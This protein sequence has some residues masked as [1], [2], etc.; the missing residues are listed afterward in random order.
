MR[1]PRYGCKDMA[2]SLVKWPFL[3]NAERKIHSEGDRWDASYPIWVP[4]CLMIPFGWL[5]RGR[6]WPNLKKSGERRKWEKEQ[7]LRS[8]PARNQTKYPETR[9]SPCSLR[10]RNNNSDN[11]STLSLDQDAGLK[12]SILRRL[13]LE[14]RQE[15]YGY[16]LGREEN[17]LILLPF[18]IRAVP[19]AHTSITSGQAAN[20]AWNMTKNGPYFWA[21]RPALLRT[22][23]QVYQEAIN[24]L[25]SGNTF[26]IK[27][28]RILDYFFKSVPSQRLNAIRSLRISVRRMGYHKMIVGE[29]TRKSKL[30]EWHDAWKAIAAMEHLTMLNVHIEYRMSGSEETD[31][32]DFQD[33]LSA[34]IEIKG[35]KNF[36]LDFG[37][38]WTRDVPITDETKA[39]VK[40]IKERARQP[41]E[42]LP[43]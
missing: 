27:D 3:E 42:A 14:I 8:C 39:L 1:E 19:E 9:I 37:L 25:Y 12:D 21:Q 20:A 30:Q 43:S 5:F 40:W 35:I 15:I 23:R 38:S 10:P 7:K 34:L 31:Q 11:I 36:E 17:Y 22:C 18:K 26:V 29:K 16:V 24:L 41:R 33:V 6:V 28:M 2:F 13:P 32:S 4:C